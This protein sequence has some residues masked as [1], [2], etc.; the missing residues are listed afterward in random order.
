MDN[1]VV[2]IASLR[3]KAD[4]Y[5]GSV[6]S[7]TQGCGSNATTLFSQYVAMDSWEWSR[8]VYVTG[9]PFDRAA[10]ERG[11]DLCVKLTGADIGFYSMLIELTFVPNK[12]VPEL[13]T[14]ALS[15]DAVTQHIAAGSYD[16]VNTTWGMNGELSSSAETYAGVITCTKY[17]KVTFTMKKYDPGFV[18]IHDH[19]GAVT[20]F[21]GGGRYFHSLVEVPCVK[22][23]QIFVVSEQASHFSWAF[24]DV[25]PTAVPPTDVPPTVSPTV[26]PPTAVPTVAPTAAPV[27]LPCEDPVLITQFTDSSEFVSDA[28]LVGRGRLH[29]GGRRAGGQGCLD[30]TCLRVLKWEGEERRHPHHQ[31]R[32]PVAVSRVAG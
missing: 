26:A 18:T 4:A 19:T 2:S 20:A 9:V 17:G 21:T 32:W 1:Y 13:L 27:V 8:P 5:A 15:P 23:K 25:T 12:G 11:D 6:T 10:W 24:F 31:R 16:G 30:G 7:I 14:P 29:H 22:G 3:M 28:P